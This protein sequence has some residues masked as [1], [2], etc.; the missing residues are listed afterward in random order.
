MKVRIA[1]EVI[2]CDVSPVAMF[3]SKRAI[4]TIF[5]SYDNPIWT[6]ERKKFDTLPFKLSNAGI[7]FILVY[8]LSSLMTLHLGLT[9]V[10]AAA[11]KV[12][13]AGFYFLSD[14]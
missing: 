2:V 6:N 10:K 7:I 1:K 11:L 14:F 4:S 3:R 13:L 5:P 8:R 9:D 12:H